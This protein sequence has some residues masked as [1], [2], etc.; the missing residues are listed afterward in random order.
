MAI[1]NSVKICDSD[2]EPDHLDKLCI[3]FLVDIVE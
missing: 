3:C 2:I 1:F